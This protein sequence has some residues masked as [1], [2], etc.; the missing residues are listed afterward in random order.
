MLPLVSADK[1][2]QL[3]KIEKNEKSKFEFN[4]KDH[5]LVLETLSGK[6]VVQIKAFRKDGT[7]YRMLELHLVG[8]QKSYF[9][10]GFC[11]K[12]KE[13]QE[14]ETEVN[15]LKNWPDTGK[16]TWRISFSENGLKIEVKGAG[17]DDK[18]KTA[19]TMNFKDR[20]E[21]LGH[22]ECFKKNK[23]WQNTDKILLF[24]EKKSLSYKAG[25]KPKKMP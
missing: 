12:S 22:K 23:A 5:S 8:K 9:K 2:N 3:T 4:L 25:V 20:K 10:L 13:G 15:D 21:V 7:F 11:T 18:L 14:R 1:P 17:E 24:N 16:K 6:Q 19:A